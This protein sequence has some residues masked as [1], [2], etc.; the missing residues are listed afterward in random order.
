MIIS[1]SPQWPV[2]RVLP[3]ASHCGLR[4]RNSKHGSALPAAVE[5]LV[6]EKMGRFDVQMNPP[7]IETEDPS[8][9]ELASF[10]VQFDPEKS[11]RITKK[12]FLHIMTSLG[13]RF[14]AEEVTSMMADLKRHGELQGVHHLGSGTLG[15]E[16]VRFTNG[17]TDAAAGKCTVA[18]DVDQALDARKRER[19]GELSPNKMPKE[20]GQKLAK[21]LRAA[22]PDHYD[23]NFRKFKVTQR[24]RTACS[25][26]HGVR[27]SALLWQR[28]CFSD[29]MPAAL[30]LSFAFAHTALVLTYGRS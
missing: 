2:F 6:F 16:S 13:D 3:A 19:V 9:E 29:L 22:M 30:E 18:E 7:N 26:R 15:R 17:F 4:R 12:A 20:D 24:N 10:F 14:E 28:A 25:R 5:R 1:S 11:G 21:M 27:A 23:E 8:F